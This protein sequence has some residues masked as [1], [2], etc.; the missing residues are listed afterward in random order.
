[1]NK[2]IGLLLLFLLVGGCVSTEPVP[3]DRFYRLERI[4][5]VQTLV[6]PALH[7]GLAVDYVQ[8]DPLR[9]GRAVLYSD[10]DHP[11]QL[12]RYHYEFWVD[13]PPRLL[14]QALLSYL[15]DSGVADRVV[16]TAVTTAAAYRLQLRLLKF[17][18][19]LNGQSAD[20]EVAMQATLSSGAADTVLWTRTYE[21]RQAGSSRQMHATAGTMQQALGE[22]FATLQAD[23]A[24]S[25]AQK[26]P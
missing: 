5:P 23:L 14:H 4:R 8:A 18:Q 13:Q 10:R 9:S 1:M 12:Q 3:E 11:L 7:G 22:L 16:D 26:K 20:V 25:P 19:V 17:E 2:T 15:R 24:A 6:K 21:H